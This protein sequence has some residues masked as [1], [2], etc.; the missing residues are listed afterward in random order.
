MWTDLTFLTAQGFCIF[1]SALFSTVAIGISAQSRFMNTTR[2]E[3]LPTSLTDGTVWR[4][5]L[6]IGYSLW[7]PTVTLLR[8]IFRS[9]IRATAVYD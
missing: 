2:R 4:H 1:E 8:P 5:S 3:V 7:K 9:K 6:A